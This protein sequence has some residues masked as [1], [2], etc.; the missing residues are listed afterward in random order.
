MKLLV[1][2]QKV[3]IDDS[4]LGFFHHWLEKLAEKVD[5][6]YIICL[7]EGKHSL[8]ENTE[9]FSLG[10]DRGYPK[11]IQL[12]RLQFFLFKHLRDVDGVFVHM[13]PIYA[14]ASFPMVKLFD[15]KMILWFTHG[16]VK[17]KLRLASHLVDRI[18]TASEESCRLKNREKIEV[19][20]HGIDTD[21]FYPPASGHEYSG[22]LNI[23]SAGRI[24]PTK[25]QE[26]LVK[27]M[28]ILVNQRGIKDL[29]IKFVGIPLDVAGGNYLRELK[30]LVEEKKLVD[31]VTFLGSVP[32][33]DMPEVYR[34]ADLLVNLSHTGSID[35]VVLEGMA[36]GCL[37]LTCNEAFK[38]LLEDKYLFQKKNAAELAEKI[39]ALKSSP[40][41]N[42]LRKE[43]IQNHSLDKLV[44]KIINHF[45]I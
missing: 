4:N 34:H 19:V 11:I 23:I 45:K 21:L 38:D 18:F 26:T 9:V 41:D 22:T 1:I 14:I 31:Y 20:G 15:R 13:C 44:G 29:S 8:P 25:D 33:K 6:L 40:K 2:T 12:I 35:K 24:S 28:D 39:I 42:D 3:D 17:W 10:K 16:T 32:H 43:V 5:K 37:I 27:A 36:S 30:E 7:W